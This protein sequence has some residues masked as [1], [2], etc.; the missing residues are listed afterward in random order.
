MF[1]SRLT[2]EQ[3]TSLERIQRTCLKVILNESYV[4]YEAAME[5]TGLE[6]LKSRRENRC[7]EFSKKCVSHD[8]N[9]R[10][11][12]LTPENTANVRVKEPF[13]VNFARTDAYKLSAIPYCQRLLNKHYTINKK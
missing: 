5:M 4:S 10:L 2:G 12:P 3:E 7:L 1:H 8:K 11:F 6:T 13:V 9:S